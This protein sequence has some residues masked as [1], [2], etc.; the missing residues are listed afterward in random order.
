[1][2]VKTA[3]KKPT[4]DTPAVAKRLYKLR[5]SSTSK[6]SVVSSTINST[7]AANQSPTKVKSKAR[8][9]SKPLKRL[10]LPA[11][12]IGRQIN[13]KSVL[14]SNTKVNNC[15]TRS[16][17]TNNVSTAKV[18]VAVVNDDDEII[19]GS[20]GDRSL[21]KAIRPVKSVTHVKKSNASNNSTV[22]EPEAA[23]TEPDTDTKTKGKR[24]KKQYLC[25]VCNKEFLGGN[26]LRKHIR[27]HTDERPY[28]CQHCNKRFRQGGCLKNHIASQHGTSQTFI[29]YYC[30]KSFPIKERLRLH[31]R[32]H[33]GEKPYKCT[34][35]GKGFARGGQ[36]CCRV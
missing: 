19:G 2:R 20:T 15:N 30:N 24:T 10:A 36:V 33:S 32:L 11:K 34:V 14:K 35:C 31:L 16:K 6:P 9:P 27:I 21:P 26:D 3:V 5:N 13:Q 12:A 4:K 17:R 23:D 8:P 25:Q 7:S 28:V 22:P 29:C 18:V 1:M